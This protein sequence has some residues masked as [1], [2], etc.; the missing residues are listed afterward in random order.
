MER[1]KNSLRNAA[2]GMSATVIEMLAQLI[3]RPQFVKALGDSIFGFDSLLSKVISMLSI[4]ELGIGSVICFSL[5]KPIAEKNHDEVIGLMQLYRNFYFKISFIILAMGICFAPFLQ[6]FT[7]GLYENNPLYL[8][9]IYGI[10]ILDA[11][12]SY[13]FSYNKTFLIA[14]QKNSVINIIK[15]LYQCLSLPLFLLILNTTNN[16]VT[17]LIVWV[18]LRAVE[19][20]TSYWFVRKKYKYL[21]D[22]KPHPLSSEKRKKISKN[23]RALVTHSLGGAF[24]LNT[25]NLI[26]SA[27]IGLVTSGFFSN[28]ITL[29]SSV[30]KMVTQIFDGIRASFGDFAVQRDQSETKRIFLVLQLVSFLI[31]TWCCVFL[32]NLCQPFIALWMGKEKQIP[33]IALVI[34]IFN[35][36]LRG[37]RS[38]VDLLKDVKGLYWQ[39]RYKSIVEGAV[40]VLFSI[41][42][43]Y[44]FGI[45]GVILG[46]TLSFI[47]VLFT[48]EPYIVYKYALKEK[49]WSYY[50]IYTKYFIRATIICT[51]R[52]G[53]NIFLFHTE[54]LIHLIALRFLIC[55]IFP[56]I[57]FIAMFYK[58]NEFKYLCSSL[59]KSLFHTSNKK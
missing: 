19:N 40:K 42:L 36:Y 7:G 38:P 43:G 51:S 27:I 8:Y 24:V 57:C 59:T 5:Y 28:Y 4:A 49:V 55:L 29:T 26:I 41:L 16:Y 44:H 39:D 10:F 48:V 50:I 6:L 25:D 21:G 14:I 34:L 20:M 18:I 30:H 32:L 17:Y 1:T 45:I 56:P 53:L 31:Y 47:T 11:F 37:L 2:V 46:T 23:I 12:F 22:K 52:L 15:I 58:T 35:F 33:F 54:N 3:I 13:F 9:T